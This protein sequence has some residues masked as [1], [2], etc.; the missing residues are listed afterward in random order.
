MHKNTMLYIIT[1]VLNNGVYTRVLLYNNR[2]ITC[3]L[4]MLSRMIQI[5]VEDEKQQSV[6]NY[7]S[8]PKQK[9][10]EPV[11]PSRKN[12]GQIT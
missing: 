7:F 10:S 12:A 3:L 5:I 6:K 8:T 2:V 4:S 9:S 11:G 1:I